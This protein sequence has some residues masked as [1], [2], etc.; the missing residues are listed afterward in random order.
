LDYTVEQTLL[1]CRDN[2]DSTPPPGKIRALLET[3]VKTDGARVSNPLPLRTLHV[4]TQ[5]KCSTLN[6][7]LFLAY[8]RWRRPADV[9]CR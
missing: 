4:P 3:L 7:H 8:R 1:Q 2:G 6:W 9:E 5:L